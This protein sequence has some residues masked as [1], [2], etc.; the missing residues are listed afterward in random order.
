MNKQYLKQEER[1]VVE[2]SQEMF[3]TGLP[4]NFV[5]SWIIHAANDQEIYE[6]GEFWYDVKDMREKAKVE[7]TIANLMA[8]VG[9]KQ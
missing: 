3:R 4:H 6:L 1:F 7:K 9:R 2:I 5:I 8:Q